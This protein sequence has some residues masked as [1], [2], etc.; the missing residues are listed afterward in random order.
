MIS[1]E[2]D[3]NKLGSKYFAINTARTVVLPGLFIE[4]YENVACCLTLNLPLLVLITTSII[5]K[6]QIGK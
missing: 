5:R 6:R 3:E 4:L 1:I 2:L